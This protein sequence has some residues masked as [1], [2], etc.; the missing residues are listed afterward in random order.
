MGII[1]VLVVVVS[2]ERLG[3]DRRLE[4]RS[5]YTAVDAWIDD[6]GHSGA[7]RREAIGPLKKHKRGREQPVRKKGGGVRKTRRK[8][9]NERAHAGAVTCTAGF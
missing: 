2:E 5:S 4:D 3:A 7:G 8:Q 1:E 6:R 9:E